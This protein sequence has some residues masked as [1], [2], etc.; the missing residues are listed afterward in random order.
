M[1]IH[2]SIL[3]ENPMGRG[4]WW[5]TVYGDRK[6]SALTEH[7]CAHT[8]THTCMCCDEGPRCTWVKA[9]ERHY[10]SDA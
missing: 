5:A 9:V 6:E 10:I 3:A 7:V 4:A 8:H 2:S 1:A